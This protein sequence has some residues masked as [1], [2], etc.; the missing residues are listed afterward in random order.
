[1][2]YKWIQ[3]WGSRLNVTNLT[4]F[5]FSKDCVINQIRAS[6]INNVIY[7][8]FRF[9]KNHKKPKAHPAKKVIRNFYFWTRSSGHNFWT[10]IMTCPS[11]WFTIRCAAFGKKSIFK[12][13]GWMRSSFEVQIEP[14]WTST[15]QTE[16]CVATCCRV[17]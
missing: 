14:Q 1:M 10:K 16:H 11:L 2:H 6:W 7:N 3:Y 9:H 4:L 15:W 5:P 8:R 17:Y 12:K 13:C